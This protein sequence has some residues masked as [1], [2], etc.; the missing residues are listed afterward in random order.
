MELK[1]IVER[2]VQNIKYRTDECF[3]DLSL[4]ER[5]RRIVMGSS[6]FGRG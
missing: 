1:N 3:D 6:M 5:R 4:V 2:F